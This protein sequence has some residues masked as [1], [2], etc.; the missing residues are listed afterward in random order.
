[1]GRFCY[2]GG[3]R[4]IKTLGIV[5][6]AAGFLILLLSMPSWMWASLA[7]I[8]LVSVGFLCWRFG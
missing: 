5:L 8:V 7:G 4:G 3:G 1:M 6:M 2:Y